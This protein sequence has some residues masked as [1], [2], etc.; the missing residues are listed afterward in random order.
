MEEKICE[1]E[2][3]GKNLHEVAPDLAHLLRVCPSHSK[4]RTVKLTYGKQKPKH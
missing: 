2:K 4:D 3:C 1:Q